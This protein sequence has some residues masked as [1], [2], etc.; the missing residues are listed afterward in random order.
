MLYP[1]ELWVLTIRGSTRRP[2]K[3]KTI[4]PQEFYLTRV[5]LK[6]FQ[7]P[8]DESLTTTLPLEFQR[9]GR[10]GRV[11]ELWQFVNGF[12]ILVRNYEVENLR[13]LLNSLR[14]H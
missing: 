13:I 14:I 1:I 9:K 8:K 4:K 5:F 11:S 2:L 12:H 3:V 10:E 6:F 7:I